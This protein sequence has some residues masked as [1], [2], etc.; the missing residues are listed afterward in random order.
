[1]VKKGRNPKRAKEVQCLTEV[2]VPMLTFA[3]ISLM[4]WSIEGANTRQANMIH[5]ELIQGGKRI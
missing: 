1:M 5:S 2:A 4:L 3:I